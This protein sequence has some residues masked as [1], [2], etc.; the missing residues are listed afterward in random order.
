MAVCYYKDPAWVAPRFGHALDAS[1]GRPDV[2]AQTAETN[3]LMMK[4]QNVP[5]TNSNARLSARVLENSSYVARLPFKLIGRVLARAVQVLFALFVVVLHPQFKWLV[6]VIAQSSLVQHYIK[7]SLQGLIT[8]VY[9]PYFVYLKELPPYWATFSIAV[10]LAVLEPAKFVAT[11]MIAQHPRMGVLLWLFL[12]GVSFV[13]IDKTWMAV[14]P[15]SRKIWLVARIHAWIWLNVEHGKYWIRTSPIYKTLLRW[16][17]T[18]RRRFRLF[19]AQFTL[20]RRKRSI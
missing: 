7:P 2:C 15:Q 14:R 18:A 10:P 20:R 12:Q 13:L 9:E 17:E 8:H 5:N 4:R 3:C 19:F 6:G 16:K 11:I 1:L